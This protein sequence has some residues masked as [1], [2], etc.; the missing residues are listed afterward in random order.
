M[1]RIWEHV[2]EV[3]PHNERDLSPRRH[4]EVY[5][6]LME[7]VPEVDDRLAQALY[8]VM[9]E[10]WIPYDDALPTLRALKGRGLKLAL[11]SNV[12]VDVRGVLERSGMGDLFDA[13][14]L[15]FEV[16]AVKPHGP[17]FERALEALGVP[18]AGRSWSATAPATTPAPPTSAS[19]RC[20]CPAPTGSSTAWR[21]CSG[22]SAP[23]APPRRATP[24]RRG[25]PAAR[26]W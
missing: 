14:I 10:T 22:S 26:G 12:G 9:L 1:D 18:P 25:R 21:W 2:L 13:V 11:I 7:R 16:G 8:E 15:S 20:S 24:R 19:A 3:D 4:R 5:D 17:I 6:A 23:D